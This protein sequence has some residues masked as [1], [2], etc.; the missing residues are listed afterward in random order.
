MNTTQS[1]LTHDRKCI[2]FNGIMNKTCRKGMAYDEVDKE[3]RLPYRAALPCFEPDEVQLQRLAGKPQCQCPH[4]Q[5]PT[6]E[7]TAAHE[8]EVQKCIDKTMQALAVVEPIRKEHKGKD[9]R[10]VL[11]CPVCKGKL[12]VR[13]AGFNGHVWAKCETEGCVAWIE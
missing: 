10:G 5:F 6:P 11:E 1:R 4:V 13:H 2:H 7:E 9:W 12:H 3:L 8:A